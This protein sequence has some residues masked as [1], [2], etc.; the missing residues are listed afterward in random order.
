MECVKYKKNYE[1]LL[2]NTTRNLSVDRCM[3][4]IV[5]SFHILFISQTH[6]HC[7]CM[8]QKEWIC[9]GSQNHGFSFRNWK[10]TPSIGRRS[11]AGWCRTGRRT[12]LCLWWSM[13]QCHT[14]VRRIEANCCIVPDWTICERLNWTVS[15]VQCCHC[16]KTSNKTGSGIC[17]GKCHTCLQM[18]A[19][20]DN[21][22]AEPW[23][24]S[25]RGHCRV[26]RTID[27][28]HAHYRLLGLWCLFSLH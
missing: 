21:R 3:L 8:W 1:H 15:I 27:W 10:E 11:C 13:R 7:F 25:E 17:W 23:S 16:W 22:R 19:I 2:E 28:M 20:Q 14:P 18:F 4:L 5:C 24:L 12:P 9:F 6:F 26:E